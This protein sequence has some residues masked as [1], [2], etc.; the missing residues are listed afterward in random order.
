M[1]QIVTYGMKK[2]FRPQRECQSTDPKYRSHLSDLVIHH[3]NERVNN[4]DP[5]ASGR[6]YG[7]I[8]K[9]A[10]KPHWK[11]GADELRHGMN[12]FSAS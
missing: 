2:E 1:Y 6:D 3:A 11:A 5:P 4:F 9:K 12:M 10:K 7:G 8:E